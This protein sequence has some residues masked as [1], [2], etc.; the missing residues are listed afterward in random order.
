MVL[1]TVFNVISVISWGSQSAHPFFRRV[2][3]ADTQHNVLS[4]TLA[5]FPILKRWTSVREEWLL[6][7]GLS[8][9][10]GRN[11]DWAGDQT[12]DPVFLSPVRYPLSYGVERFSCECPLVSRAAYRYGWIG[13]DMISRYN[14]RAF[15]QYAFSHLFRFLRFRHILKNRYVFLIFW[16]HISYRLI[17]CLRR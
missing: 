7:Q 10:L 3:F 11:I 14:W 6:S 1:S 17:N 9:I 2:L 5:V 8:S 16:Q 15:S 13:I 4:K 12:S